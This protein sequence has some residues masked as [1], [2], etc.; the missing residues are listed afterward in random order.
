M[1]IT[2]SLVAVNPQAPANRV[3]YDYHERTNKVNDSVDQTAIHFS[4]EGDYVHTTSNEF[5]TQEQIEGVRKAMFNKYRA[6]AEKE[7]PGSG[8]NVEGKR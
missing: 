4:M 3:M 6:D 5:R 2:R 7:E 8:K 1:T